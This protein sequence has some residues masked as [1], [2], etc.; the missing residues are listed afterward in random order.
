M[1]N[2]VNPDQTAPLRSGLIWVNT[3]AK[4][5]LFKC[6][7]E[8]QSVSNSIYKLNLFN[9]KSLGPEFLLQNIGSNVRELVIQ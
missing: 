1:V 8:T 3:V 9:W 2:G 6:S 5:Y 7:E 4:V